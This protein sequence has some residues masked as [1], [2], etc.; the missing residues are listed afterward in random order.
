MR[1]TA[2][3]RI[4]GPWL[5]ALLLTT[6]AGSA[7]VRRPPRADFSALLPA[8]RPSETT[9]V[10]AGLSQ[11]RRY[12][13]SPELALP[14][15][16]RY[17]KPAQN[18]VPDWKRFWRGRYGRSTW[19][20]GPALSWLSTDAPEPEVL[21]IVASRPC[22]RW[23]APRAVRV[24]TTTGESDLFPLLDCDGA[25][26]PEAIDRLSVLARPPEVPRPELPLPL[27]A[28]A[29]R[30]LD[31]RLVWLLQQV[32]AAFPGRTIALLSGVR[33]GHSGLHQQGRALD[34]SVTGV[35]NAELFSLCKSLRDVGCGF[36]PEN[37]FVHVD[38]RPYATGRVLWVDVSA[39]GA[40]SVYVD[41]WPDLVAPGEAWLGND[42]T[43]SSR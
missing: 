12:E 33:D 42:A 7:A 21:S 18:H 9:W 30:L 23:R 14:W 4:L 11:S 31:P 25:I 38:V 10:L 17:L 6:S 1:L 41:G 22:P 39:P 24:T 35:P 26:A 28:T 34:I 2:R 36:Y 20:I 8:Q 3:L 27:E 13:L 5:A 32:A 19:R 43:R 16:E 40:P 29:V 37:K 15:L